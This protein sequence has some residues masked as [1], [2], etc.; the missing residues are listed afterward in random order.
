MPDYGIRLLEIAPLLPFYDVDPN[1]VQFVGTGVWD[2]RVFFDEPSLQGAI[3]SG[4]EESN[5]KKFFEDY[6]YIYKEKPSR[7]STIPYDVVGI[8]S[9]I[10][11]N[12]FNINETFNFLNNNMIK[13]DGIDG[14]FYFENNIMV[15]ELDILQIK[16][17]VAIKLN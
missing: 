10:L 1:K 2:D 3:F 14:K 13:F 6:L 17:G 12:K 15:R 5:R 11:E 16:N 7:I 9:Y 8:L 4:I